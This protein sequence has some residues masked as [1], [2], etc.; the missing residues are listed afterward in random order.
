MV[1]KTTAAQDELYTVKEAAALLAMKECSLRG[2]IL[3]ERIPYVKLLGGAVRIQGSVLR[4]IIEDGKNRAL[5]RKPVRS[6]R[7]VARSQKVTA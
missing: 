4:K 2:W 5:D 6:V 1:T 3:R 7:P